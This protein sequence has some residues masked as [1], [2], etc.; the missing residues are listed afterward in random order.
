[1]V[2]ILDRVDRDLAERVRSCRPGYRCDKWKYC[3][4]CGPRREARLL[5]DYSA[6]LLRPTELAHI[7][8]TTR[9]IKRLTRRD[10]KD[11]ATRFNL[12]RRLK[13][14]RQAVGGAIVNIQIEYGASGWLVHLHAIVDHRG[15]LSKNWLKE[16]WTEL[17]GG[18]SVDFKIISS[19]TQHQVL[20]Y[21]A[22]RPDLPLDSQLVWQ[23][24]SATR[25]FT[26]IRCSGTFNK[27]HGRRR[28][29]RAS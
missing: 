28:A 8:L 15:G 6:R 29:P 19:E 17:G 9:S 7:T 5:R 18:W 13:R 24:F 12:L 1:M 20:A 26:L 25:G 4:Y 23:F 10:L 11:L 14:F 27:S 3:V 2:S 21:G 16:E 22:R